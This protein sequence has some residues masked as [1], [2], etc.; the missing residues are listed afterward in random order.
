M[1]IYFRGHFI[2]IGNKLWK[3]LIFSGIYGDAVVWHN[4]AWSLASKLLYSPEIKKSISE[5]QQSCFVWSKANESLHISQ[6]DFLILLLAG[7]FLCR[8]YFMRVPSQNIPGKI[9][10]W[11]KT[12]KNIEIFR[13]G[14]PPL[15]LQPRSNLHILIRGRSSPHSSLL[16]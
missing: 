8:G 13:Q 10:R 9:N 14:F 4:P 2:N 1:H 3:V 16:R 15:L 6:Q 5:V 11:K 7:W 12:K